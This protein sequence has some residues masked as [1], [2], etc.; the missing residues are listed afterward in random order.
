MGKHDQSTSP[1]LKLKDAKDF[2]DFCQRRLCKIE[3]GGVERNGK[4]LYR[5]EF[6]YIPRS[7]EG[8][9]NRRNIRHAETLKGSSTWH[10]F[11]TQVFSGHILT[12][13]HSCPSYCGACMDQKYDQCPNKHITG[14]IVARQID[15]KGMNIQFQ[16]SRGHVKRWG[17]EHGETVKVGELIGWEDTESQ[18][19]PFHILLVTKCKFSVA[20]K[21][22]IETKTPWDGGSRKF[23]QGTQVFKCKRLRKDDTAETTYYWDGDETDLVL[24]CEGIRVVDMTISIVHRRG[25]RGNRNQT[26]YLI[27]EDELHQLKLSVGDFESF[28]EQR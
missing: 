27:D 20:T 22:G 28:L 4:G 17:E 14:E 19:C 2:F 26:T 15:V 5:R 10:R 6:H 3:D 7:G 9:I 21:G 8:S 25:R 18:S 16:S 1:D 13:K 12:S 11:A 24:D 23:D